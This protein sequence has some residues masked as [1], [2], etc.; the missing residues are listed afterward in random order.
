MEDFSLLLLGE[1]GTGKSLVAKAIGCSGYIPFDSA[2]RRFVESFTTSFKAI[3][4]SQFSPGVLESELFG[5]KKGAFT[6]ATNHHPGL[7]AKCSRY[8]SVFI[9]EIGD[10]HI[11]IQ[12]KLLNVLQDRCFS[13]VGSLEQHRFEGRVISATSRPLEQL[14]ETGQFRTDFYYRLC[15]DVIT[16][17][18]LR[19]RIHENHA[20]LRELIARLLQR[21]I[22][23]PDENL[24]DRIDARIKEVVPNDYHWPGNVREL[25]QC[26][27]RICLTGTYQGQSFT[28]VKPIN[29]VPFQMDANDNHPS[30]QQ[31]LQTYCR[32]LYDQHQ[33]FETVARIVNLDRRTVKKY[34]TQGKA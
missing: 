30:A 14:I 33:S 15:S 17:P 26:I 3:N 25:E 1:T 8:G 28:A 29:A 16:M 5:H 7:F 27:R 13:P 32:Y 22:K 9:D 34:I 12:V 6:G 21:V 31:L 20:E 10:I 19:Q 4:L 18:S 11:P 24:I 23:S 2:S